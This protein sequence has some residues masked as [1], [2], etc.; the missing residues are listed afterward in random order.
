MWGNNGYLLLTIRRNKYIRCGGRKGV[1]GFH[2]AYWLLEFKM[3]IICLFSHA[4]QLWFCCAVKL[5]VFFF[6]MFD[7]NIWRKV[8]CGDVSWSGA[9][10]NLSGLWEGCEMYWRVVGWS[11]IG[12]SEVEWSVVGLSVVKWSEGLSN[13]VS[14]IIRRYIDLW[15]LQLIWLFGLSHSFIFFGIHF[16]SLYIW[17]CVLCV[18]V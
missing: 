3:F 8:K 15:S 5:L 7:D 1:R 16:V 4:E 14:F 17:L 10:G 2:V 6:L 11:L 13:R 12:K 9:I 18:S